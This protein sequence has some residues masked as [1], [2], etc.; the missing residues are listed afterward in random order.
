MQDNPSQFEG[1]DFVAT[2]PL[3]AGHVKK[4]LDFMKLIGAKIGIKHTV[5]RSAIYNDVIKLYQCGDIVNECPI[6]IAYNSEKAIDDGGVTRDMFSS[7]W[8]KAYSVLFDGANMLVPL[9]HPSTDMRVFPIL[10]KIISHGYLV[11][12]SLPVRISLPSL[13]EML[14]GSGIDIPRSFMLDALMDY[15]S[16]NER[17]KLMSA[18]RIKVKFPTEVKSD[19]VSILSRFGCREMPTPSNLIVQLAK[20]EFC[21]KPIG[22]TALVFS[23]IPEDHKRFWKEL[24]VDGIASLYD[25]LTA[26]TEKVLEELDCDT[27]NEAER[28]VFGYLT[29]MIGNMGINDVRNFLRFSTGSSV[30]VSKHIKIF[31]MIV[32]VLAEVYLQIL[33]AAPFI[34][35]CPT[36]IIMIS[37]LNGLLF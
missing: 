30:C 12:G 33:V 37:L 35:Q 29:T 25:S 10:G 17:E 21:S 34:Y 6:F 1:Y 20:F 11:S 7:F 8:E 3:V 5:N 24:G 22:V 28:R 26:T 14:L 2:P 31:L 13:L 16:A 9:F 4:R 15:L 32:V 36:S 19:L 18:L 23:G 27:T